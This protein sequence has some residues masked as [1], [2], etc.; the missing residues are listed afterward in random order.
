MNIPFEVPS[1][2]QFRNFIHTTKA[3]H[4]RT[5]VFTVNLKNGQIMVHLQLLKTSSTETDIDS[6]RSALEAFTFPVWFILRSNFDDQSDMHF[7]IGYCD[8]CPLCPSAAMLFAHDLLPN[9]SF[10]HYTSISH[11]RDAILSHIFPAY[12]EEIRGSSAVIPEALSFVVVDE[13]D[14]SDP[15]FRLISNVEKRSIVDFCK[16]NRCVYIL[17]PCITGIR[18]ILLNPDGSCNR[19]QSERSPMLRDKERTV[20]AF[21]KA[22]LAHWLKRYD[23]ASLIFSSDCNSCCEILDL[24]QDF[25]E[26]PDVPRRRSNEDVLSPPTLEKYNKGAS[27]RTRNFPHQINI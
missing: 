7:S 27:K 4:I 14:S 20:Y 15:V 21:M 19:C 11:L 10:K 26:P 23:N 16:A 3:A 2:N 25:R 1:L 18:I 17:S 22:D 13:C 5:I 24:E 8:P 9:C 12:T 6:I